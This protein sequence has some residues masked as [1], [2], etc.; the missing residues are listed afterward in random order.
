VGVLQKYRDPVVDVE[1]GTLELTGRVSLVARTLL[2]NGVFSSEP[3]GRRK[4]ERPRL[5]WLMANSMRVEREKMHDTKNRGG[6][7]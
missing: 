4:M 6:K 7:R 1:R 2:E 5:K 3:E